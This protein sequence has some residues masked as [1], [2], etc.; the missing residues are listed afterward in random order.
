MRRRRRHLPRAPGSLPPPHSDLLLCGHDLIPRPYL[1]SILLVRSHHYGPPHAPV[2]NSPVDLDRRLEG[3]RGFGPRHRAEVFR[4]WAGGGAGWDCESRA[5]MRLAPDGLWGEGR[6]GERRLR[7]QVSSRVRY[8]SSSEKILACEHEEAIFA[9][10][11]AL[12]GLI[13]TCIDESLI[14]QGV[15]Q[16]K[17][18]PDG[19]TRRSAPTII[20]KICATVESF[21]GYQYSAVWDMAFPILSAMFDKLGTIIS[22]SN[23]ST[24]SFQKP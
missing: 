2:L 20:E 19:D 17:L 1:R 16:I 23:F 13:H 9:A 12:K 21:L 14:K 7:I 22:V 8:G 4:V 10:A 15:D 11:E 6:V 18:N 24:L 3:Q 5:K